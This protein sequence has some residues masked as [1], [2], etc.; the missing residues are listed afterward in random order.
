MRLIDR[1]KAV[2]A[3]IYNSDE[4]IGNGKHWEK[5]DIRS[6]DLEKIIC[7]GIPRT[8]SGNLEKMAK[9]QLRGVFDQKRMTRQRLDKLIDG[10]I[11]VDRFDLITLLFFIYSQE[12]SE[13][14]PEIRCK[15]YIDEVNDLLASCHLS[16]LYAV[17]PYEAS[18]LMCLLSETPLETYSDIWELSYEGQ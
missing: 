2:T 14:E 7:C 12:Q 18:I 13:A 10:S 5:A 11:K 16:G 3:N 6:S 4:E 1:A 17:N 9:S 15:R 8:G